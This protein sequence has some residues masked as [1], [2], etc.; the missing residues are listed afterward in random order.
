MVAFLGGLRSKK[1]LDFLGMNQ[2]LPLPIFRSKSES[3]LR[4][5]VLKNTYLHLR[6]SYIPHSFV[7]IEK[8]KKPISINKLVNKY[9]N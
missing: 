8:F 6:R 3:L 5:R 1:Y 2:N 7:F 9:N 4:S